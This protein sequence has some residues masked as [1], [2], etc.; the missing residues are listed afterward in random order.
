MQRIC[1]DGSVALLVVYTLQCANVVQDSGI[2]TVMCHGRC[3]EQQCAH[4][5]AVFSV[6]CAFY[7][8]QCGINIAVQCTIPVCLGVQCRAVWRKARSREWEICSRGG[9]RS[10]RNHIS[11]IPIYEFGLFLFCKAHHPYIFFSKSAKIQYPLSMQ[12]LQVT[13]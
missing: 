10:L 9:G 8:V 11:I 4:K 13:H 6:K 12:G 5:I 1:I 3:I 2:N 7:S